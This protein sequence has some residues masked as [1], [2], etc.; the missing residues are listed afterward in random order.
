MNQDLTFTYH[1]QQQ[2]GQ[3]SISKIDLPT[4]GDI[5]YQYAGGF[6]S[7]VDYEDGTSSTITY[8][9]GANGTIVMDVV[10]L[11]A[12]PKHRRKEVTFSGSVSTIDGTV[13]P[14]AVGIARMVV[15]GE[16]EVVYL[17]AVDTGGYDDAVIYHGGGK[18]KKAATTAFTVGIGAG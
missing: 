14:T 6:L 7:Q 10:D 16:D 17:S 18:L 1:A 15:N 13:V 8:S 4:G 3:W 5:D 2:S 12:E 11:A 9:A